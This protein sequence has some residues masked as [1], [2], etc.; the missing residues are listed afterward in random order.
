MAR[1]NFEPLIAKLDKFGQLDAFKKA[2]QK[3]RKA[4]I[5]LNWEQLDKGKDANNK[6]L[7][8]YGFRYADIKGRFSPIDLKWSGA[9]RKAFQ[10]E[11]DDTGITIYSE[12][13]KT[14]ILVSR[15]GQDIFGL[16]VT[17]ARRLM[18][19]IRKDFERNLKRNAS[20]N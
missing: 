1:F 14:D 5:A 17:N 15:Y 7:G 6:S 3:N 12:D 8:K 11:V 16:N 19:I 4:I 10:V 2:I 18:Q 9:F 20:I 13:V